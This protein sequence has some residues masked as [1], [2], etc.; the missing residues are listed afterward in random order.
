[1]PVRA[2]I[3][4][5]FLVLSAGLLPQCDIINPEEEVPAYIHIDSIT[6]KNAPNRAI[7]N[8]SH[9]IVDA[10]VQVG[11]DFVGVFELPATIPVLKKEEQEVFIRAGILN[12]GISNTR[13]QYPFYKPIDTSLYLEANETDSLGTL[14]AEYADK[15]NYAWVENFDDPGNLSIENNPE[16]NVDFKI[17][18]DP[19]EVFDGN[20]SL[21][22]PFNDNG[23]TRFFEV[24]KKNAT[25]LPRDASIYLELNFKTD[26]EVKMGLIADP[27]TGKN[28]V[29]RSKLILNETNGKW[30]K[31]YIN[32]K[33]NVQNFPRKY[34]FRLFFGKEK[35]NSGKA[36]FYMDNLKLIHD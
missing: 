3:F 22:V 32:L 29:K 6:V 25:D 11:N 8:A 27:A 33:R 21:K 19:N 1:M 20:G 17:T 4:G 28:E 30:K 18:Q 5:L 10:W 12:N 9:K 14:Q 7:D 2:K 34:D 35:R 23:N 24:L 13:G 15:I 36:T 16:A 26:I 31:I